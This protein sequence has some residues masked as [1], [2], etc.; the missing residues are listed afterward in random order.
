MLQKMLPGRNKGGKWGPLKSKGCIK[1]A[2]ILYTHFLN[3][4]Y[5][6]DYYIFIIRMNTTNKVV[7]YPIFTNENH[8]I[9]TRTN[10]IHML[11]HYS[12][13]VD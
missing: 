5:Y 3:H 1:K 9:C 12:N 13:L 7:I 8:I 4:F 11:T 10:K 2:K 6:K